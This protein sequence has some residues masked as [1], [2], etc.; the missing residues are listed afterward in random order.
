MR[1][2]NGDYERLKQVRD[3]LVRSGEM[4]LAD[5]LEDLLS[6]FEK[7]LART[8]EA[9]RIRAE[10]NRKAGYKWDSSHHPRKSKYGK[11][12]GVDG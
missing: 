7:D 2:K 10:K 1:L 5:W 8:R 3:S 12:G 11:A 9:N 4:D 6:E